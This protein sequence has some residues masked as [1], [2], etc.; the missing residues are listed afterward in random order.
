MGANELSA[1]DI[2]QQMAKLL[3]RVKSYAT[4]KD[5]TEIEKV[6]EAVDN[7]NSLVKKEICP[8]NPTS[9]WFEGSPPKAPVAIP[10][11]D[12]SHNVPYESFHASHWYIALGGDCVTSLDENLHAC[13]SARATG[14]I[15]L[16]S[17]VRWL[18][19]IAADRPQQA[20]NEREPFSQSNEYGSFRVQA[21]SLSYWT[22]NTDVRRIDTD[23]NPHELPPI[24]LAEKLLS[25][26]LLKVN[27]SFPI[28]PR[29]AFERQFRMYF[30]AL[31]PGNPPR[32]TPKWQ[33]NL[34]LVFA[35]GAKYSLLADAE[36]HVEKYNHS[37]FQ[38]R[39]NVLY[40]DKI[41]HTGSVD[42]SQIQYFGLLSF[43]HLCTGQVSR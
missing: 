36:Q 25:C 30:A 3:I 23:I 4:D 2:C 37:A 21:S 1:I 14:Y 9:L 19:S 7:F 16:S 17:E 5:T 42:V 35:I 32:L 28:L 38:T 8:K 10:D 12:A 34:N 24:E 41:E 43:Y 29:T 20:E 40:F 22:D 13:D 27:D 6:L 26:Y 31:Q 11:I 39:A 15:G 33:A 18:Q